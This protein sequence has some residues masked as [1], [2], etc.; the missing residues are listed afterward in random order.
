[1]D[2]DGPTFSYLS[3]GSIYVEIWMF[4]PVISIVFMFKTTMFGVAYRVAMLN[5]G[6]CNVF[7]V[8]KQLII[9]N[10]YFF[11]IY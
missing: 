6:C 10:I 9:E 7:I 1:M 2:I 8:I 5:S 3:L 11:A 4:Y